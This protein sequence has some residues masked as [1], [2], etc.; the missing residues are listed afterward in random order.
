MSKKQKTDAE[1][2]HSKVVVSL[3]N[4]CSSIC[5]DASTSL[6]AVVG[7]KVFK[8]LRIQPSSYEVVCNLR[9]LPNKQ[10]N[11]N[12]SNNDVHFHPKDESQLATAPTNGSVVIWDISK[13][14]KNKLYHVFEGAHQRAVNK[15]SYHP[16]DYNLLL[17]GAQDSCMNIFDTRQ[18]M[19]VSAFKG[20]DCV[21]DVKFAPSNEHYFA[22]CY[23][24]GTIQ[25]WDRR[26]NEHCLKTIPGHNGPVYC[27]NWHPEVE[28]CILSAGRDKLI[29]GY[30]GIT[31]TGRPK[32]RFTVSTP[33]SVARAKWRPGHKNHITSCSHFLDNTVQIWDYRRPFIP[34]ASFTEHTDD[35]TD[36]L[37]LNDQVLISCSKDGK[38][39]QQLFSDALRPVDKA[40]PV[41]LSFRPD[42]HVVHACSD[43]LIHKS[44][45]THNNSGQYGS[46]RHS[47]Q[48]MSF[49]KPDY[50]PYPEAFLLFASSLKEHPKDKEG[51]M[52]KFISCAKAFK[53]HGQP[54]HELCDHNYKVSAELGRQDTA[55]TWLFLKLLYCNTDPDCSMLGLLQTRA[56]TRHT[57]SRLSNVQTPVIIAEASSDTPSS[58]HRRDSVSLPKQEGAPSIDSCPDETEDDVE[59]SNPPDLNA[60]LDF[61][62]SSDQESDVGPA[63]II[64]SQQPRQQG[65][66]ELP[67][68]SI[69]L[70]HNLLARPPSP[71]QEALSAVSTAHSAQ[72]SSSVSVRPQTK[73]G[74]SYNKQ[75][76]AITAPWNFSPVVGDMLK[77][78]AQKGD[79]QM[80]VSVLLVLGDKT[81]GLVN[82]IQQEQWFSSY[83]D[84]LIRYELWS[85]AALVI[86]LCPLPSINEM[87]QQSTTYHIGCGGCSKS[88]ENRGWQCQRCEK[89]TSTCSVCN[90]AVRGLVV[91]CQVCGHGG[92]LQHITQWH[93]NYEQ[94]PAGCGHQ[95]ARSGCLA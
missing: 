84:L 4:A 22:A 52:D 39:I 35:V 33:F 50:D 48:P 70:R 68:E 27:C 69:Q 6:I 7:R 63:Q 86:K 32:E 15:V 58:L 44:K 66:D 47:Y 24:N 8:V 73:E 31:S 45:A 75:S 38:V 17:S 21:R 91:W 93:K 88:M 1:G 18:R 77:F 30:E 76:V 54:M 16:K 79:V 23:D 49:R 5:T 51:S 87:S 43:S 11:L 41:A 85:V 78:Y 64:V 36:L 20:P 74:M 26:Y 92:H 12:Y 28:H 67:T 34:F 59:E 90:R 95:C 80:S 14:T 57:S 82:E 71:D 60:A 19:V 2:V 83:I 55:Q 81:P 94:C 72:D 56:P 3:D 10:L 13:R 9:D 62:E 40:T 25:V 53:L 42:G 37:W 65:W 29:K 46:S 61:F 89:I